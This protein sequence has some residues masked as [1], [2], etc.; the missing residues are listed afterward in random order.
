MVTPFCVFFKNSLLRS[1]KYE[2]FVVLSFTFISTI[3]LKFVAWGKCRVKNNTLLDGQ[4]VDGSLSEKATFSSPSGSQSA[5]R[6]QVCLSFLSPW[7]IFRPY[8]FPLLSS[9]YGQKT[10]GGKAEP[11][12]PPFRIGELWGQKKDW[13]GGLVGGRTQD[14]GLLWKAGV[15]AL[16]GA[17]RLHIDLGR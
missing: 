16:H 12:D 7:F 2:S 4:P 10:G 11:W 1:E 3:H 14:C 6:G 17:W 5:V 8:K 15:R 9:E 13:G